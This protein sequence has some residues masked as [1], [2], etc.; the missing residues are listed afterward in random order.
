MKL[1]SASSLHTHLPCVAPYAGAGIEIMCPPYTV[2]ASVVAP[3]AGAGIEIWK[4][5]GKLY[6]TLWSPPTR[7]RELK[8]ANLLDDIKAAMSPPT[9]GRELKCTR[10]CLLRIGFCRPLRGGGN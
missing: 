3:Y 6:M 9:R 7:G 5:S 8:Y 4:R 1:P 10:L 2:P